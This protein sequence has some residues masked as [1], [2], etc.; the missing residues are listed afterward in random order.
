[1]MP[2][3]G[4]IVDRVAS[5]FGIRMSPSPDKMGIEELVRHHYLPQALKQ[6]MSGGYKGNDINTL[7][8]LSTKQKLAGNIDD[9][10]LY[11]KKAATVPDTNSWN[12]LDELQLTLDNFGYVVLEEMVLARQDSALK[13]REVIS[14]IR[15]IDHRQNNR[16][17]AMFVW[18]L[19]VEAYSRSQ[20]DITFAKLA[21]DSAYAYWHDL[22]IMGRAVDQTYAEFVQKDVVDFFRD[23]I[24]LGG[25]IN[26]VPERVR[27]FVS[28]K[29]RQETAGQSRPSPAGAESNGSQPDDYMPGASCWK[30][31]MMPTEKQMGLKYLR[32]LGIKTDNPTIKEV[33]SAY[34]KRAHE[35]HPD[36]NPG[37]SDSHFKRVNEAWGYLDTHM[38]KE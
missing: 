4:D 30:E 14:W 16:A 20:K 1:M 24:R 36:V 5:A 25:K 6:S 35:T 2:M 34:R 12:V 21:A 17:K 28:P 8:F 22:D 37:I 10:L 15:E 31:G 32:E 33:R 38:K 7:V 27:D 13:T 23:Y 29:P 3:I 18:R 11:A 26:E 9:A 19:C